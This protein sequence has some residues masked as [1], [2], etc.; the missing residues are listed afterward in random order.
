MDYA[1]KVNE[2]VRNQAAELLKKS[3]D[4]H[5]PY[6]KWQLTTSKSKSEGY[7]ATGM[8]LGPAEQRIP[9]RQKQCATVFTTNCF[10]KLNH[11]EITCCAIL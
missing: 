9:L 4:L 11:L 5:N 8:P 7:N 10:Y 6:E 3:T 1:A 2:Y